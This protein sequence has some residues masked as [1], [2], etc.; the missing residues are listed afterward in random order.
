M[1]RKNKISKKIGVI[2]FEKVRVRQQVRGLSSKKVRLI[3]KIR[4]DFSNILD[5]PIL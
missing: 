1:S 4:F 3:L 2:K 5:P